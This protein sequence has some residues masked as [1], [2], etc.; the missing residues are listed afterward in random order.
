MAG[1]VKF[2]VFAKAPVPGEVKTRLV[3]LLGEESAAELHRRLVLHTLNTVREVSDAVTLYCA[4]D[5]RHAFFAAC[6][7]RYGV[8][9]ADQ[10][11]GD[12]G[13]R[14]LQACIEQLDAGT[15]LV[16]VG[17]DCP[18]LSADR[19][20]GAVVALAQGAHVSLAPAEDGGYALI[21]LKRCAAELFTGIPWG[22]DTVMSETRS[23]LQRLG[24]NW[25]ELEPVWDVDR[26][27][28]YDRLRTEG[29]L[30]VLPQ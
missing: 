12:L 21:G 8:E 10:C 26:P 13:V 27:A 3:P 1:E 9:L 17:T 19:L 2:L 28:D 16:V 29:W 22:T 4:P 14:M 18:A 24:W 20:G 30:D 25:T 7:K 23:R 11:H 15:A 6:A 5:A